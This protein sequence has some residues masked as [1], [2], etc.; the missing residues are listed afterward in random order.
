MLSAKAFIWAV[1]VVVLSSSNPP[2]PMNFS[3][4]QIQISRQGR[5]SP[6]GPRSLLQP[7]SGSYSYYYFFHAAA[8]TSVNHM[9]NHPGGSGPQR[10]LYLETHPNG[11]L[12]RTVKS[13]VLLVGDF[14]TVYADRTC[15]YN[16]PLQDSY[17]SVS[18]RFFSNGY[19]SGYESPTVLAR[20]PA[21]VPP[22]TSIGLI[23]ILRDEA[24]YTLAAADYE[25]TGTLRNI[26]VLKAKGGEVSAS[27]ETVVIS[28]GADGK[29]SLS[30]KDSRLIRYGIPFRFAIDNYR[31]S[32][33]LQLSPAPSPEESTWVIL[34]YDFGK[35]IQQQQLRAGVPI[36]SR[37]LQP[38]V[39]EEER[40]IG[41]EC[42]A[43]LKQ[44]RSMGLP[45]AG[46]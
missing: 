31:S 18:L 10:L 43:R 5:V 36:S 41:P 11:L 39:T 33:Q 20:A 12:D 30:A 8:L 35:T 21:V 29:Y 28:P 27:T 2:A 26:Q 24:G 32:K 19:P 37:W 46:Y 15:F 42:D 25:A 6:V 16:R 22:L 23:R 3:V 14:G 1:M 13:D 45:T 34:F 4:S 9:E 40:Q 38:S 44:Q 17:S 7:T